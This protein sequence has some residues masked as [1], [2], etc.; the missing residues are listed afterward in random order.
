MWRERIPDGLIPDKELSAEVLIA[1]GAGAW[2]PIL[3]FAGSIGAVEEDTNLRMYHVAGE[4][5]ISVYYRYT[6]RGK[7]AERM[8]LRDFPFDQQRLHVRAVL[9]DCPAAVHK[10]STGMALGGQA[11]PCRT[12]KF[13]VGDCQ[14]NAPGSQ[15]KLNIA[16]LT[17]LHLDMSFTIHQLHETGLR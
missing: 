15:S 6:I 16:S 12:L 5:F 11:A 8:E 7:F 14:V 3:T 10:V 1:A 13:E 4:T 9:W 17:Y 2:R